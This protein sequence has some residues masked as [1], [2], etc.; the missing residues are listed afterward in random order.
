MLDATVAIAPEPGRLAND[1]VAGPWLPELVGDLGDHGPVTQVA[2]SCGGL[3]SSVSQEVAGLSA[4]VR[5]DV[6]G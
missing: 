6:N 2:R 5:D 3:Y 1:P 4:A